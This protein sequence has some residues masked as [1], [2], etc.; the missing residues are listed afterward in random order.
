[1]TAAAFHGS[2]DGKGPTLVLVAGQSEGRPVCVFGGYAGKSWDSSSGYADARD[3]FLF[4]V[5]NPF[6][7]GIVKMPVNKGG[8]DAGKAMWCRAA[9]GPSFGCGVFVK[10]LSGSPTAVFDGTSY[11]SLL[12]GSTFGNP[13]G[14]G[15]KTF[16]G[17]W[18]FTP[19]EIEVWRAR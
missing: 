18:E 16:T 4:T 10:S 13:L 2:C 17:A 6:G 1:M 7:D 14:R 8:G 15:D 5:V 12:S 11:C 3:S 19:L 9:F